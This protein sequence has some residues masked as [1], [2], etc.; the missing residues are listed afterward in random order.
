M[1]VRSKLMA[2]PE[3]SPNKANTFQMLEPSSNFTYVNFFIARDFTYWK[4]T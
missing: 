2:S 3:E 4:S 1:F